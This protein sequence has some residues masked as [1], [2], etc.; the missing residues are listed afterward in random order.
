MRYFWVGD[1]VSQKEFS[2]KWH[3]GQE[4]LGNY[5]SKHHLGTHYQAVRPWYLNEIN[6]PLVLPRATRPSTLRGCVGNPL[7]DTYVMYPYHESHENRVLGSPECRPIQYL[8]TMRIRMQI[9]CTKVHVELGREYLPHG[10]LMPLI[11]KTNL[12]SKPNGNDVAIVALST[13]SLPWV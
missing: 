6:S 3:P 12:L 11:L 8:I 10:N 2:I 1:K 9:L 13:L 4:N 7:R 5:Q